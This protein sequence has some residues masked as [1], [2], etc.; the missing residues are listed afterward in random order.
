MKKTCFPELTNIPP[1]VYAENLPQARFSPKAAAVAKETE[2]LVREYCRALVDSGIALKRSQIKSLNMIDV[3][4]LLCLGK[5]DTTTLYP[6]NFAYGLDKD[7]YFMKNASFFSLIPCFS[8]GV[9]WCNTD[10]YVYFKITDINPQEKSC[11]IYLRDY[12]AYPQ[13]WT[14]GIGGTFTMAQKGSPNNPDDIQ[15]EEGSDVENMD[16]VYRLLSQKDLGWTGQQY[17][18]WEKMVI[19]LA[20]RTNKELNKRAGSD[21]FSELVEMFLLLITKINRKL[22]E[23]KPSRPVGESRKRKTAK[24]V[25]SDNIPKKHVR[26]VGNVSFKSEKP[27]KLPTYETV[28]HYSTPSW[29]TRGY[30]RTYKSGKQVYIPETVHKRKCMENMGE[31]ETATVIRFRKEK[32]NAVNT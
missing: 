22:S 25:I 6:S 13:C 16:K 14:Y 9:I 12:T 21:Q 24:I 18:L 4:P 29:I 3:R 2:E 20:E 8:E 5:N 1:D 19:T 11:S 30:V 32:K 17:H 28:I 15:L 27:P 10:R 26:M 7:M 23:Q 31:N